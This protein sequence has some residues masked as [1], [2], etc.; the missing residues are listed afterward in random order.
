MTRDVGV[1]LLF[2]LILHGCVLWYLARI[3]DT[4]V[5]AEI[6][7]PALNL[8]ISSLAPS[9]QPA[10]PHGDNAERGQ[11]SDTGHGPVPPPTS[12]RLG[13]KETRQAVFV[14]TQLPEEEKR[15]THIV[16][17]RPVTR[18]VQHKAPIK[19][20]KVIVRF[21]EI[22]VP[23]QTIAHTPRLK[24][25]S[26]EVSQL[27]EEKAKPVIARTRP[28]EPIAPPEVIAKAPEIPIVTKG[29]FDQ[30]AALEETSRSVPPLPREER[31]PGTGQQAYA[32]GQI[33]GGVVEAKPNYAVNPKPP[34]PRL[35][36]RKGYEGTVVLLVEVLADGSVRG[37]E[38]SQSSGYPILDR[39]AL[40]TVRKWRFIP[41]KR[42]EES[43]PMKVKL[44]VVFR[45][46][47][48][49]RG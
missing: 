13:S 10:S 49:R 1:G 29:S 19:P 28:E 48:A 42:G 23:P 43:V 8:Y 11:P 5:P 6:P 36:I 3:R 21:S 18:Q 14:K 17:A 24:V 15:L 9:R 40:K 38:I 44:P 46:K 39:C 45:L 27:S 33:G 22:L 41:G 20:P 37:V 7:R 35:A 4:V 31:S 16:K 30:I 12:P 25:S 2:S 26:A 32:P 34:Y 47:E